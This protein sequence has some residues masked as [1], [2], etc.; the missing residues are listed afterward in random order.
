MRGLN[1]STT[2][3]TSKPLTADA[4]PT[5]N[6]KQDKPKTTVSI[7]QR[8]DR[9]RFSPPNNT[10]LVLLTLR[11]LINAFALVLAVTLTPGISLYS[12]NPQIS[13]T[14]SLVIIGIV[15]GIFNAVVRPLLLLLTGRLVIRTMGLFLFVNQ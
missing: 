9:W 15:F 3:P 14:A 1:M 5:G 7:Q 10:A 11:V 13:L 8:F 4:P 12:P 6:G 2:I